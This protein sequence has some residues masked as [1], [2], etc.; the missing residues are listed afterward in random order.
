M[1]SRR[2]TPQTTT[3]MSEPVAT[4]GDSTSAPCSIR[5]SISGI[6]F[7]AWIAFWSPALIPADPYQAAKVRELIQFIDL[8]LE[9][10]ARELYP[11]AF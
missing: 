2:T 5:R 3:P 11:Q 7:P 1:G 6:F 9:L 4:C 8:H 10:V